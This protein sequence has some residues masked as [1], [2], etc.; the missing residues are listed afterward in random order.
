MRLV[1]FQ[2]NLPE[3]FI[4]QKPLPRRDSAKLMVLHKDSGKIEHRKFTNIVDYLDKEDTIVLNETKVFPARVQAIKEKTNAKVELFLLRELESNMW[5]VLVKPARKVRIGN[6]LSITKEVS[7]DVIDNTISGGRVVRFS[8]N[9][10][11]VYKII[12]KVGAAP[13]P[14]YIK[15]KAT[16]VDKRRYQTVYARHTGAVA[17]PTAGLHFTL[18]LLEKIRQKGVNIV[19]IILNVGLGT[20]K[21]VQVEDLSRHRMDSEYFEIPV[22]AADIV[23]ETMMKGKK[24]MGIGTTSARALE[25][26]FITENRINPG[27]GWTDKFIFPPYDFKVINKLITNFHMPGSTLLMLVSA[28]ASRDLIFHAYEVAKKHKYRFYSYGDAMLI[29]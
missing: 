29:L 23:N 26:V 3:R 16:A 27:M 1:E 4:A 9:G 20:F 17:A 13:L 25:S 24:I 6:K 28:F 10:D 18:P 8:C 12:D 11:D 15:R 2:Y 19:P 22:S 7:C 21:P 5:E 14:P